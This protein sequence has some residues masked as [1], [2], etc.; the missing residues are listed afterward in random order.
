M[1]DS[2]TGNV[3]GSGADAAFCRHCLYEI[4]SYNGYDYAVRGVSWRHTATGS[5]WCRTT[6]AEPETN[7]TVIEAKG[8]LDA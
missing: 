4:E 7:A 1:A 8:A 3:H 6:V 5:L 2:A